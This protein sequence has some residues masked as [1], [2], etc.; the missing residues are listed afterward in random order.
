MGNGLPSPKDPSRSGARWER[1]AAPGLFLAFALN[2]GTY[3]IS[4]DGVDYY[5][6]VQRLFG[7]RPAGSGY[8]FGTGLMNA[9]FYG[10]AKVVQAVAGTRADR[11][12]PGSI[13]IASIAYVLLAAALSAWLVR[14]IGL[15]HPWFAAV[16]AVFG[17]PLWYYAS[18]DPSYTHAADA[19]AFSLTAEALWQVF[20]R[21]NLGWR[22]VC[23]AALGLEVAVRPFNFSL[24]V[25]AVIALIAWKRLRDALLVGCGALLFAGVLLLV[26]LLLGTGLR[27]RSDGSVIPASLLTFSPLSPFRMLATDHR[28]LFIWTPTTL[29]ATIGVVLLLRSRSRF[30]PFLSTLTAMVVCLL[31]S[32]A[33]F[34]V[35]DAGWSFSARYLAAPLPFYALG[36][37]RLFAIKPRG[38]RVQV[39]ALIGATVLWSVFLGMTHGFDTHEFEVPANDGAIELAGTQAHTTFFKL[40]WTYSELRSV[41]K[42]TG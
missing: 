34:A 13:T 33:F 19:A 24:G 7:D 26:P 5:S 6:F 29:L 11:L 21:D 18:F 35:W 28:G 22:L 2:F 17:S 4:G 1:F 40:A 15:P 23:G 37:A 30:D 41:V 38:K 42:A 31:A 16:L 32:Y 39:A 10:A 25:G 8:N 12:L 9:P 36:L 14:R 3:R 20:E 27:T